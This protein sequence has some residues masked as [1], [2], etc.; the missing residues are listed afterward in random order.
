MPSGLSLPLA[1]GIS[2]PEPIRRVASGSRTRSHAFTHEG[3]PVQRRQSRAPCRSRSGGRDPPGQRQVRTAFPLCRGRIGHQR[4][5]HGARRRGIGGDGNALEHG[6]AIG[7]AGHTVT[8]FGSATRRAAFQERPRE[9]PPLL[10]SKGALRFT[11][12]LRRRQETSAVPAPRV[13]ARPE[14]GHER[15]RPAPCVCA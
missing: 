2:R 7:K 12:A 15:R 4:Q 5:R 11:H 6:E 13:P 9:S 3:P 10:G 14:P 1:F 8:G